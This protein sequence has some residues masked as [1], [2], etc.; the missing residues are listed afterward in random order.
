MQS[1]GSAPIPVYFRVP[2]DLY[3]GETQNLNLRVDERYNARPLADGSALRMFINGS[4]INEVP[5][6]PG[7]GFAGR[8]RTVLLPVANMRPFGNTFLFNFDFIP[9]NPNDNGQDPAQKLQGA[10]LQNSA[11]DIRGLDHWARMPN[12]EL[13][14]N[15]GFPFT[16]KADLADTTIV[17]PVQPTANE[18]ALLLYLMSHCGMQTGYPVLRVEIAGPDAVMRGDHDYLILGGE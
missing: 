10:I 13:F 7:P 12:L 18:I 1:N 9:S 16:R 6:T 17:V 8:Q 14:A 4:L 11:L 15:A 5:L 2:P 3:Y